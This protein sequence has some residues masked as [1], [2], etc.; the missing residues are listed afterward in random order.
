MGWR[1]LLG[2]SA[3]EETNRV[4]TFGSLHEYCDNFIKTSKYTAWNFFPKSLFEQFRRLGNQ[5]FLLMS[6]LMM[7][8]T[9]TDL[10]QSPI[11]PATTLGPLLVVLLVSLAQEGASDLKR[12]KSDD[13]VNNHPAEVLNVPG[14]QTWQEIRVGNI[15]K[16]DRNGSLPADLILLRTSKDDGSCYI[17]TSQIDGET[18]LKGRRVPV[19]VF[20]PSVTSLEEVSQSLKSQGGGRVCEQFLGGAGSVGE[21]SRSGQG[22]SDPIPLGIEHILLRGATIRNTEWVMGVVVYTGEDTKIMRNS[23]NPPSKLSCIDRSINNTILLIFLS[24]L[25]LVTISAACQQIWESRNFARS[26]YLGFF[27]PGTSS[28]SQR[29]L[30]GEGME[31][32]E[33]ST[34]YYKAWLTFLVLYNNFIP[35]SCYVTVEMIVYTMLFFINSDRAIYSRELDMPAKARSSNV[36]DLGQIQYVFSDKTGTLTQNVMRFKRCSI[37]G[38][39]YGEPAESEETIAVPGSPPVEAGMIVPAD[40]KSEYEPL[41][42]LKSKVAQGYPE[43]VSFLEILSLAH[44]VVVQAGKPKQGGGAAFEYQAESPD[45]GAL[46]EEASNLGYVLSESGTDYFKVTAHGVERTVPLLAVNKF[47]SNRKRMSVVIREQDGRIRL[48]C[49]GADSSMLSQ[50]TDPGAASLK[51]LQAHLDEFACEG[52]R[53]LVLG[54]RY[55]SEAAWEDWRLKYK[56]AS[57]A[58]EG[59]AEKLTAA[60]SL[61]ETE[62]EIVGA[63]AI[64]DKLQDGVPDTIACLN[65]AGIKVW[66]LTGD[67]RETAI[68]IGFSCHVLT[69]SMTR[70]AYELRSGSDSGADSVL[71]QLAKLY[72]DLV[73]DGLSTVMH[74]VLGRSSKR[75]WMPRCESCYQRQMPNLQALMEREQ[76]PLVPHLTLL[77]LYST[78]THLTQSQSAELAFIMEGPA[79]LDV[80]G[81]PVLE[82][83]LFQVASVCTAVIACRVSPKQKAV[84]VR[85]VKKY[86]EPKPVTLSIGDG[87][88]DVPMLQEAQVGVGISGKEGQQAVNNS[89]FAV[90][91]FRF[92]KDLLLV[93]G[94]WNYRRLSI[95]VLYSFFKNYVLVATLFFYNFYVG[96]SGTPLYEGALIALFNFF[97]GMPIISA[98]VLDRD[99]SREYALSHPELYEAGRTNRDLNK[100]VTMW[101]ILS[102][103][104]CSTLIYFAPL[105]TF[106]SN[107][108]IDLWGIGTF[109]TIVYT[110]L[111]ISMNYKVLIETRSIVYKMSCMKDGGVCNN[112]RRSEFGWT[113]FWWFGS[114]AFYFVSVLG[115]AGVQLE[116]AWSYYWT[117]IIALG[118]PIQWLLVFLVTTFILL[119]DVFSKYIPR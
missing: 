56:Q 42:S 15:I 79:L 54:S 24:D 80:F 106:S 49:K 77:P 116:I 115:Y 59:R 73:G 45:E 86:V 18:N 1:D 33:A 19:D 48:L 87:A 117:G 29:A 69:A 12:H 8:G 71:V 51:T 110:I 100:S 39:I 102:A 109:G 52:L 112:S 67:K 103:V 34:P 99:V 38:T 83:M 35:I 37:G 92:L 98:G 4:L 26:Q 41:S 61:I 81:D 90:A 68:N 32:Q 57:E 70:Y 62:L 7:L 72:R 21:A 66:V 96:F 20:G 9:Y 78:R 55:L 104:V 14:E 114:L 118:S 97:L 23:R 5:Y 11:E 17:E 36:T 27:D 46:V 107:V 3:E 31:W 75:E 91:Q 119:L 43:C 53:T 101:W 94:R 105:Y 60:G 58:V 28:D 6:V 30:F 95:V 2:G 76:A 111:I 16:V 22:A 25:V 84:L 10:F 63:T 65:Q 108:V 82:G 64:E 13:A 74:S 85:M 40:G 44:T 47:D 88:N 50:A 93:H 113:L 89:D